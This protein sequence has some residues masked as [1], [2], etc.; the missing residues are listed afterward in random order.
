[1]RVEAF[2]Y[3]S[4]C[5]CFFIVAEWVVKWSASSDANV[6]FAHQ[7]LLWDTTLEL[8]NQVIQEDCTTLYLS[9]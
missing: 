7:F 9:F 3:I 1:M 8:L 4:C 5:T 6:V 2:L